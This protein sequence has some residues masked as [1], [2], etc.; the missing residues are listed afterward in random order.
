MRTGESRRQGSSATAPGIDRRQY[1]KSATFP[2]VTAGAALAID[3]VGDLPEYAQHVRAPAF[4]ER[5][6]RRDASQRPHRTGKPAGGACLV[7]EDAERLGRGLEIDDPQVVEQLQQRVF[8]LE[9][10][11]FGALRGLGNIHLGTPSENT[12]IPTPDVRFQNEIGARFIQ[13]IRSLRRNVWLLVPILQDVRFRFVD[14]VYKLYLYRRSKQNVGLVRIKAALTPGVKNEQAVSTQMTCHVIQKNLGA[15]D[16]D[17]S[18][19]KDY[20]HLAERLMSPFGSLLRYLR[21]E[22]GILLKALAAELGISEKSLS[23][24]ETG[25]RRPFPDKQIEKICKLLCLSETESAALKVAAQQSHP[26]LR[27]PT[28]VSPHKYR[29][30]YSFIQSL[31]TLSEDQVTIIQRT[32]DQRALMREEVMK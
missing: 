12:I 7:V 6:Q 2:S 11:Q 27:I 22:R 17:E 10:M 31:E 1:R 20:E 14:A 26:H 24:V 21:N 15:I 3:A 23:A 28:G 9:L 4:G 16:A 13:G 8:V 30:A 18:L 19:R 5:L 32:L 29:L 25:R